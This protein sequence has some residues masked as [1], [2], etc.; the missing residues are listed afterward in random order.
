M[1]HGIKTIFV[2]LRGLKP[3]CGLKVIDE[4]RFMD[5]LAMVCDADDPNGFTF[6]QMFLRECEE[7][8]SKLSGILGNPLAVSSI[9]HRWIGRCAQVGMVGLEEAGRQLQRYAKS[10][11]P[12]T[13]LQDALML[14]IEHLDNV[15]EAIA[16]MIP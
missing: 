16:G 9:C 3:P 12:M 14:M 2:R 4:E 1:N 11:S 15:R 8:I 6:M 7:D 5:T 13:D 10:G